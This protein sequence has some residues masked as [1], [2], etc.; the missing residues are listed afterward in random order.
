M[1]P[2]LIGNAINLLLSALKSVLWSASSDDRRRE[3]TLEGVADQVVVR[4]GGTQASILQSGVERNHRFGALPKLRILID[5]AAGGVSSVGES[6]RAVRGK[7]GEVL[8]EP[9]GSGSIPTCGPSVECQLPTSQRA[10][11]RLAIQS[12]QRRKAN[13]ASNH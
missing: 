12:R 3:L 11:P 1:S 8:D 10:V 7:R 5:R 9:D 6:Q 13:F 2:D 4:S